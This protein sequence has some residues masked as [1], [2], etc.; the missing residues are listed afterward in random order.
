VFKQIVIVIIL[1]VVPADG[2]LELLLIVKLIENGNR[3]VSMYNLTLIRVD[4]NLLANLY[5]VTAILKG[6]PLQL[7]FDIFIFF[8]DQLFFGLSFFFEQFCVL[9]VVNLSGFESCLNRKK[10]QK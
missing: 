3:C 6:H 2:L 7:E 9:F 5:F 1:K 4:H 8:R 10:D